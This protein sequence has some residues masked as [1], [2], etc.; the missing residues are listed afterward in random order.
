MEYWSHCVKSFKEHRSST[1]SKKKITEQVIP[2]IFEMP[3]KSKKTENSE[4]FDFIAESQL[5]TEEDTEIGFILHMTETD[6]KTVSWS[7]I[8]KTCKTYGNSEKRRVYINND[9]KI[10]GTIGTTYFDEMI[11]NPDIDWL[12]FISENN[13]F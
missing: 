4:D 8:E 9:W 12:S 13:L 7:P 5:H 1:G 6:K 3:E 10:K 2:S 11:A